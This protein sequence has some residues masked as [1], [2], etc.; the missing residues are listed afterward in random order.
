VALPQSE[1]AVLTL[2]RFLLTYPPSMQPRLIAISGPLKGMTVLV[3]DEDLQI[4]REP[5]NNLMINDPLVSRRHCSIGNCEGQVRITDLE[6]LNGTF[7]NDVK[8][9]QTEID[10]RAEFRVGGTRL[11]LIMTDTTTELES[12]E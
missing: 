12:L 9:S 7:V 5:A 2:R 10:N 8:V 1:I 6:S 3:A 11:M 4:G